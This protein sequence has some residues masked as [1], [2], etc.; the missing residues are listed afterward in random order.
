MRSIFGKWSTLRRARYFPGAVAAGPDNLLLSEIHYNPPGPDD[1]EFIEFAN[2]TDHPIDLTGIQLG[3]AVS[4]TFGPTFLLPGEALL[5]VEDA[6]AFHEEVEGARIA[7]QWAGALSNG[8]ETLEVTDAQGRLLLT[9]TYDD[10]GDWPREADGIGSTLEWAGIDGASPN[11]PTAWKP[12]VQPLGSPGE[13]TPSAVSPLTYAA[14]SAGAFPDETQSTPASDPDGDGFTNL[15][16]F[17]VATDPLNA[18]DKPHWDIR[19]TDGD[20]SL[21]LHLSLGTPLASQREFQMRAELSADL[22]SWQAVEV[23]PMPAEAGPGHLLALPDSEAA[24]FVRLRF[25][26]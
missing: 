22:V 15:V 17:C 13:F 4:F 1:L 23:S 20:E 16:E 10:E 24:G 7:G 9:L 5:V 3:R 8:G 11:D 14:W 6:V 2:P 18:A 25:D 26:L 12:S 21:G 19:R